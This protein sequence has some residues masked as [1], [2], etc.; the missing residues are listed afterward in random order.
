MKE[1]DEQPNVDYQE[2]L[3]PVIPEQ[4]ENFDD[5]YSIHKEESYYEEQM[6]PKK[7]FDKY[8]KTKTPGETTFDNRLAEESKTY[9]APKNYTNM[10]KEKIEDLKIEILDS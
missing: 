1:V 7:K 6:Q 4:D 5:L 2:F 8:Q 3:E 9:K 10:T